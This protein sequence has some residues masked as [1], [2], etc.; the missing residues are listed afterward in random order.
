MKR[1]VLKKSI[2]L[3]VVLLIAMIATGAVAQLLYYYT[4]E[5]TTSMTIL[6]TYG[7][8]ITDAVGDALTHIELGEFWVGSVGIFPGTEVGEQYYIENTG[9][10]IIYAYYSVSGVPA[11]VIF[12]LQ[13]DADGDDSFINWTEDTWL[14]EDAVPY[15]IQPGET[16]AFRVWV[17]VDA[18]S[19]FGDFN[20]AVVINT[21]DAPEH[22]A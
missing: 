5:V 6:A 8:A 15:A 4:H 13:H 11:N 7:A 16:V 20:P 21:S 12:K 9:E 14:T 22:P 18:G 19:P 10:D 3:P 1:N 2:P 17:R